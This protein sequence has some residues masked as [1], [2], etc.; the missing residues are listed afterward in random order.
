MTVTTGGRGTSRDSSTSSSGSWSRISSSSPTIS[1]SMPSSLATSVIASSD[2]DVV[3]VAISPARNRIFTISAGPLPSFSAIVLRASR[4]APRGAS[5]PQAPQACARP[6]RRPLVAGGGQ[7]V[8]A[9]QVRA[10]RVPPGGAVRGRGCDGRNGSRLAGALPQTGAGAGAG[11]VTGAWQQRG[12]LAFGLGLRGVGGGSSTSR[13]FGASVAL[14]PDARRRGT[15][16]SGTLDEAD[17]PATPMCSS[18]ASN[19]LLVTPSSFASS[20]TLTQLPSAR[21][22]ASAYRLRHC[23]APSARPW[24]AHLARPAASTQAGPGCR[25]APRPG[26][27]P[28]RSTMRSGGPGETTRTSAVLAARRAAPHACAHRPEL[29]RAHSPRR[30]LLGDARA[31]LGSGSRLGRL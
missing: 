17:L 18:V 25:Y 7:P 6:G 2:N 12:F 30:R 1:A 29:H 21:S 23:S 5:G 24:P 15:R 8:R 31:R 13:R 10:R 27:E 9:L 14:P 22:R 26:A 3:A 20:W 11:A 28:D 19:S 16:S 4:L